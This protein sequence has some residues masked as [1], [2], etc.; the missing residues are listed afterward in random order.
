MH[1]PRRYAD[2][3]GLSAPCSRLDYRLRSD[4]QATERALVSCLY[5]AC[6]NSARGGFHQEPDLRPFG[7][8]SVVQHDAATPDTAAKIETI[9]KEIEQHLHDARRVWEQ[10]TA[11]RISERAFGDAVTAA[12]VTKLVD[13]GTGHVRIGKDVPEEEFEG[14]HTGLSFFGRHRG[15]GPA[16]TC[17]VL[18]ALSGKETDASDDD[19]S[20]AEERDVVGPFVDLWVF[21]LDHEL[22]LALAILILSR[23]LA[24]CR[25]MTI[26]AESAQV[27]SILAFEGPGGISS[28]PE[29]GEVPSA[30]LLANV[31]TRW[32][33]I[34]SR[35]W[36]TMQGRV[37]VSQYAPG[38][39]ALL[40]M[41]GDGGR[42]KYDPAVEKEMTRLVVLANKVALIATAYAERYARVHGRP[43]PSDIA[44]FR[45]LRENIEAKIKEIGLEDELDDAR[46]NLALR[47]NW[48]RSRRAASAASRAS[49]DPRHSSPEDDDAP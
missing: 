48:Y 6:G 47:D 19:H 45:Q 29:I 21:D 31:E 8:A 5:P 33:G 12:K 1:Y 42:V 49:A 16:L 35:S 10:Q 23:Y 44:T 18:K 24:I 15:P 20:E 38:R 11:A 40:C 7:T 34:A 28:L 41:V 32:K 43:H 37:V 3:I 46:L 17:S 36:W 26:I 30:E 22:L 9:N 25:P 14:K 39:Y 27:C 4:L 2:I 13:G